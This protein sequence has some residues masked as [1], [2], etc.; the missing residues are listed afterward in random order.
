MRYIIKMTL[1]GSF[2]ASPDHTYFEIN[3][4]AWQDIC[5]LLDRKF[6]CEDYISYGDDKLPK[7]PPIETIDSALGLV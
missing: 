2:P 4:E 5:R 6:K 7:K 3:K 1:V